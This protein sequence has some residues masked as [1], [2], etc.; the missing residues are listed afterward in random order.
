VTSGGGEGGLKDLDRGLG[1]QFGANE[2]PTSTG[3]QKKGTISSLSYGTGTIGTVGKG[4]LLKIE[5]KVAK[6]GG[7]NVIWIYRRV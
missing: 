6:G 3:Q 1:I 7:R 2:G 5:H 4:L